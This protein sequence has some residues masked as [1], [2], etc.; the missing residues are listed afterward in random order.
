[1]SNEL[2]LDD[3]DDV[4]GMTGAAEHMT[5]NGADTQTLNFDD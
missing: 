1:M 4:G 3:G 5:L 2:K